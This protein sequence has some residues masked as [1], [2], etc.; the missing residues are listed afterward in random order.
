VIYGTQPEWEVEEILNSRVFSQRLQYQV[1]WIGTDH[2]PTYYN[3]DR[4][5]GAPHALRT[6][7]EAYPDAPGPPVNLPYWIDCYLQDQEP[8]ERPNDNRARP[9][10]RKPPR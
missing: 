6:F 4:F 5:K 3:A 1:K 7:H 2:D 10:K 8:E 9:R